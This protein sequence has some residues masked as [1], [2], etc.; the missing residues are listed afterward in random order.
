M[1]PP[2]PSSRL[3]AELKDTLWKSTFAMLR[4]TAER[5][6]QFAV[7]ERLQHAIRDNLRSLGYEI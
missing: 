4:L 7:S 2:S 3:P 6:G 1:A 5:R